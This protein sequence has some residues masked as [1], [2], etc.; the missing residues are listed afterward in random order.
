MTLLPTSTKRLTPDEEAH[1]IRRW[2]DEGCHAS[3]DR[4]LLAYRPLAYQV[5]SRFRVS[6]DIWDDLLQDAIIGMIKALEKF[7]PDRGLR[8]GTYAVW[9]IRSEVQDALMTRSGNSSGMTG[10]LRRITSMQTR[11]WH[12]AVA[13]L[14]EKGAEESDENILHEMAEIIGVRAENL[15]S[16]TQSRK[17]VSL[18]TRVAGPDGEGS[19]MVDLMPCHVSRAGED[20]V[21]SRALED[22]NR[23]QVEQMISKLSAREADVIRRRLLCEDVPEPLRAIGEDYGLTPERVRQIEAI[24]L[25]KLQKLA[26]HRELHEFLD[27]AHG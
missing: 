26:R 23:A 18:H 2:K 4:L 1:L 21:I 17:V 12:K 15:R 8:F 7:D 9:W 13:S 16:F 24:A 20:I 25:K 3:R 27:L 5:V 6:R 14:R 11:A 19:E 22:Y 10:T